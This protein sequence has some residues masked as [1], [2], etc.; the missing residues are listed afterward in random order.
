MAE[1]A[2]RS[3]RHFYGGCHVDRNDNGL[4]VPQ[5]GYEK[6]I[7]CFGSNFNCDDYTNVYRKMNQKKGCYEK[8]N[9]PVSYTDRAICPAV[10]F[11]ALCGQCRE[12][13]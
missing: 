2:D 1:G 9:D 6:Y 3:D 4:A 10:V 5:S 11:C 7:D 12:D 13:A 8:Q